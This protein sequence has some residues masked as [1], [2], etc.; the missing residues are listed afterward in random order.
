M[1]CPECGYDLYPV[2][3]KVKNHIVRELECP[4]CDYQTTCGKKP[5]E[6]KDLNDAK[7]LCSKQ[8]QP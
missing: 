4:N 1:K 5:A 2:L 3:R 8:K 7:G 6:T